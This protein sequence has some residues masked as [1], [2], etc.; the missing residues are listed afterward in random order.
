MEQ[1][2]RGAREELIAR[3]AC[4]ASGMQTNPAFSL[5]STLAGPLIGLLVVAVAGYF[6]VMRLRRASRSDDSGGTP[7]SLEDLRRLRREGKLTDEEYSRA[8]AMIVGAAKAKLSSAGQADERTA[9]SRPSGTKPASTREPQSRMRDKPRRR[10]TEIEF[11][12]EDASGENGDSS[13][14]GDS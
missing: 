9:A 14:D 4:S 2:R 3:R 1:A 7:F 12:P 6:V 10:P 8:H 13:G 5:F 11:L